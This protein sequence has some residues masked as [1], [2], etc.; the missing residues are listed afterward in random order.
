MK[1]G[2]SQKLFIF[3]LI[4]T[5][6]LS[7]KVNSQVVVYPPPDIDNI[8]PNRGIVSGGTKI[9]ITGKNLGVWVKTNLGDR[10]IETYFPPEVTIGGRN[11]IVDK[12][13]TTDKQILVTTPIGNVGPADVRVINPDGQ[14]DTWRNGFTYFGQPVIKSIS[15]NRGPTSGD[16][17]VLITGEN[18]ADDSPLTVFLPPTVLIGRREAEVTGYNPKQVTIKTPSG[19]PGS[20]DV[21]V[22]NRDGLSGV[23]RNGFIYINLPIINSISPNYGHINGGTRVTI[24]G[25]NFV[26]GA[27]VRFGQKNASKIESLSATQI[28]AITPSNPA[29]WVDV[30]ITN[31]DGQQ[32]ILEGGFNY[33][34]PAV[35]NA[36]AD[37]T[38]SE[39]QTV[40]IRATFTDN[41]LNNAHTAEINWGDGNIKKGN[42]TEQGY[43]GVV[44]GSHVYADNGVYTVRVTVTD[45]YDIS[46][47]DTMR[48]TINNVVP[49]VSQINN[50]TV[51]EGNPLVRVTINFTDPGV[52]DTHKAVISW[53]DG[54]TDTIDPVKSPFDI[55]HVYTK[56][57]GNYTV[58]VTVTDDDGGSGKMSFNVTVVNENP[59]ISEIK[60][61]NLLESNPI[62]NVRI[63][64]SDPGT[65]DTHRA[66]IN[67]GDGKTDNVN[68]ARS[69]INI[70]HTYLN[71]DG[72][73]K[74]T[75]T[76]IDKD[77]GRGETSFNVKVNNENPVVKAIS[78]QNVPE[79]NPV[80]NINT[81][82]TDPG[83]LDTHKATI[84]WGDGRIET[85]DPVISPIIA[86]HTY[87]K[88]DGSYNV[89]IT[90]IDDDGGVG[91]TTFTV[92]VINE[93]PVVSPLPNLSI[94]EGNPV[95][96]ISAVFT[97]PGTFD[98]HRAIINWGDGKTD[99]INPAISPIEASHT[100]PKDDGVYNVTVTVFD[101]SGGSG[102]ASFTVRVTNEN[103]V[104]EAIPDQT[105][106]E[107]NPVV[108]IN[109]VFT[110][111]GTLDKHKVTINWG[112]GKIDTIDP[113]TSPIKTNHTYPKDD[114][115]YRATVT[116]TDDD[117]GSGSTSFN[118]KV[119][120]EN[121][122][123]SPISDQTVKEGN[124][125]IDI[126][127]IFSDP[128]TLDK[129]KVTINWG[130]GKTD[131]IDPAISPVKASHTYPKDDGIYNA[132]VTVN[133]DD[134]GSDKTSFKVT[135]TN[136][137]PVIATLAEQNLSEG[138]PVLNMSIVFTD[139]G[140][141]DT[142]KAT[143]NWGDG[144]TETIDP[145]VSPIKA[146]HTYKKDN[147]IYTVIIT[148]TDDN[149]GN[150]TKSFRV[151]VNNEPPIVKAGSDQ[152]VGRG[153]TVT[154]T[155]SFTDPSD[156]DTHTATIDWGE[157]TVKTGIVSGKDGS[158]TV[159]G[160]HVYNNNG[161]YTVTIFVRDDD[162]GVGKDTLLVTVLGNIV[163]DG[164]KD[165]EVDEGQRVEIKASFAD[166][167]INNTHTA[168]IDWGD[169]TIDKAQLIESR[170]S[171]TASGSHIYIDNGV[172]N[173]IITVTAISADIIIGV[174]TVVITVKNVAPKIS[175][176][177]D[178]KV[179][180]GSPTVSINATFTDPGVK[181]THKATIN[182]GDGKIDTINPVTSPIRT[183]HTYKK[184]DGVYKVI[185]TVTDKD[186][187]VGEASF[188]VTVVNEN[189]V[190]AAIKDQTVKEGNPL[191]N[192]AVD[193]SDAGTLDTHKATIN[194]G[195][196]KIDTIDPAISPIK[197]S[198]TYPKDDG[199][200][201]A[202]V[203]V[204]DDDNGSATISFTVTVTNENPVIKALENKNLLEGNPAL[205]ISVEFTDPGTLDKHKATIDWGDGKIDNID[206]AISPI[207]LSHT[208]IKDD[209]NYKVTVTITDD[210]GGIGT[211]S[212]MVTV[213]NENPVIATLND[214]SVSEG[215]P[216][217]SF[218]A[219][220][221]DP[222][223][224]DKH[225]ATI[226]WGD[227]KI[228][229]ID[230]A[231][232]PI[233]ASHTYKKDD[234]VYTVTVTVTDDNGGKD[235]KSFKITVNNV[236]P[237][238]VVGNDKTANEGEI[239]TISATFT[240]VGV[241]DTHTATIYWGDD[242]PVMTTAVSSQ[243]GSGTITG[244]HT[245]TKSGTYV[246]TVTVTD[247]D[248]GSDSGKFTIVV[249]SRPMTVNTI[250]PNSGQMAG[251]T[252]I[253]ITGSNFQSGA[254]V[255]IGNNPATDV[256]F[257][258]AT[259]LTAFT[260]PGQI[261]TFDV[262]V[263]NPNRQAEVLKNGFTYTENPIVKLIIS[264]STTSIQKGSSQ[265][266]RLTGED[267]AGKSSNIGN[268]EAE[269]SVD[270]AQIGRIDSNG[271]FT[272]INF[273]VTFVNAVLKTNRSISAR[274]EARILD[275]EPPIARQA[276]PGVGNT[277]VSINSK[278]QITFSEDID[279][280]TLTGSLVIKGQN[281]RDVKGTYE[282]VGNILTFI[283]SEPFRDEETINVTV[284]KGL[285]DMAG[286]PLASEFLFSFST[287]IGVWSG[288]ANN[289]G[290]VD[291][292]DIL[293][294]GQYWNSRGNKR[295]EASSGWK[296]Q[297][298]VP[299]QPDKFATYADT[300]GDGLVNEKDIVPIAL[301]WKLSHSTT[302]KTSP[303][304]E[305]VKNANLLHIYEA[306]YDVL[307]DMT[308]ETDGT[309]ALKATLHK[310]ISEIKLQE[311]PQIS[312]LLQNYPNPFN[313][314]TWIP[315]QLAEDA[316]VSISIYNSR[317]ILIKNIEIGRKN[318]G[319]Y[320]SKE[321]SAYWDG[322]DQNGEKVASGVYFC[323]MQARTFKDVKK[324]ILSE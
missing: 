282:L 321:N 71:D 258:S 275:T 57:D 88:N 56:D 214:K 28:I 289:D 105:V 5:S 165:R 93:N 125:A 224:L 315:Y 123:L 37:Q 1:T 25:Q 193:F 3:I 311:K 226:D 43:N 202:T 68:P 228:D 2:I 215:N 65:L 189:P 148:V 42:V 239:V 285:K 209:G 49:T 235:S 97:D 194:W 151:R 138:N 288:D 99:T 132:T 262:T 89:T 190:I 287:G 50:Q 207:N 116:V 75:V 72:S 85:K 155:A 211:T 36:G 136:E 203:T 120:N 253:V 244:S 62:A 46:G 31:P 233:N 58:I 196:G 15:P 101:D 33:I 108:N 312:M 201:K 145:A 301:N 195:D 8:T 255:I 182:W 265:T 79:G 10:I 197:A 216:V 303:K 261:G 231:T 317:G 266:F 245:Y 286:N 137:N 281:N 146:N 284:T 267:V 115:T 129:H 157:G 259:Q 77:N 292:L 84:N 156:L 134:G 122:V 172:Y 166:D 260:P 219:I 273:G 44:T 128:G 70:S 24:T 307:N 251:G 126:N 35:V 96:N 313:P 21:T 107:G 40:S 147:D 241:L 322:K 183:S 174:D 210:D 217:V 109:I 59:I 192:I 18:F 11:A 52:L 236:A 74:V 171:G 199:I 86:S 323:I 316:S 150:D 69:P 23:L 170:G 161:V 319:Y 90:V 324:I 19:N 81:T 160:S 45:Q 279:P 60:D 94:P 204:T 177:T 38:S 130:D 140:T 30:I 188:T 272:A 114:G 159:T 20:V 66:T 144:K 271:I 297:P 168:T 41:D 179:Y 167:N 256:V 247:D 294:I 54:K 295:D 113:A 237:V 299:W 92:K 246:V 242:T 305:D 186:N 254:T 278:I 222:G 142:H 118:V 22:T 230:P 51:P 221:T 218:S 124:P 212:F 213:A 104:I 100:Y 187:G 308:I 95:V 249:S 269:W 180:E 240:D 14:T 200:Y 29:G 78:D 64:F 234:G 153:N 158:G 143:I 164:G 206:P 184:D 48:F 55:S 293:P 111:P 238:I 264:P 7:L 318:A 175:G 9:A 263:I 257:I 320:V 220:F 4:L 277:N 173:A 27:T 53:G 152:K 103:P 314:E 304:L 198:H 290:I 276:S 270:N 252:K 121:P 302:P 250:S 280:K 232:S 227:G 178:Q 119:T 13:K 131:T 39:G 112:D 12:D 117:G 154:I 98:K 141:L 181:D 32:G 205:N 47:S 229:T 135:V 63:E 225:K 149:G 296:I 67:W 163:V 291:I 76:I 208:Y 223:T 17:V 80:V 73:Y 243:N 274:A 310:I 268:T 127:I 61:L 16:T 133:D 248:K 106:K 34:A 169:G 26:I 102:S 82:F 191:V 300:N 309:I 83:K 298:A 6:F 91:T 139:P 110:D 306:M 185:V 283:P 87:P 162:G 176:I